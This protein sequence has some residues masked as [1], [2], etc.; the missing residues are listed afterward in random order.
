[1][2]RENPPS[3]GI[4]VYAGNSS[5]SQLYLNFCPSSL[6]TCTNYQ[7][8][9]GCDVSILTGG[10]SHGQQQNTS[11]P[12]DDAIQC[13]VYVRSGN[14]FK[15]SSRFDNLDSYR[16]LSLSPT[17]SLI[18]AN[19]NLDDMGVK[20]AKN[21]A[22]RCN[23]DDSCKVCSTTSVAA[24]TEV[25][26]K[27]NKLTG[28]LFALENRLIRQNERLGKIEEERY[29]SSNAGSSITSGSKILSQA[30]HFNKLGKD[31]NKKVCV[32]KERQ[33]NI[34]KEKL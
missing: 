9:N 29:E 25:L 17:Y 33:L 23:N 26:G 1:M 34:L 7:K 15:V 19:M 6:Y 11:F 27:L 13:F 22:C 10:R 12:A 20:V 4:D 21:A 3:Q 28:K 24:L 18:C 30:K 2:D 14:R 32:E 8:N 5:D 31:E 16:Q